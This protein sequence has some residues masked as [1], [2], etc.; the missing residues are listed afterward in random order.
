[1]ESC[2][3]V[4]NENFEMKFCNGFGNGNFAMG[5]DVIPMKVCCI[6]NSN[7]NLEMEVCT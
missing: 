1:M 2:N 6:R 4:G 7:G 5:N 3:G